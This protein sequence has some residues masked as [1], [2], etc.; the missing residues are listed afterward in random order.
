MT[1]SLETSQGFEQDKIKYHT[2][3]YTGVG[4]GLD[5]GCGPNRIWPN[6]IGMDGFQSP[7]GA[8]IVGDITDLSLFAD[9]SFPWVFSSHA[10]EDHPSSRNVEILREWWRVLKVGGYLVLY[11]PDETLYPKVGE[12]GANPAHQQNLNQGIVHSAM[13]VLRSEAGAW[14]LLVDELRSEGNEYSFLQVYRKKE[15]GEVCG[16][17]AGQ[18]C[19]KTACVV[20]FGGFG[21]MLQASSIFPQLKREGYRLTVMTTPRGHEII[22]DDPH[23]DD[24]ILQ[25]T[26]QVPNNELSDYWRVQET[27]F[28]KFVNLSESVEGTLL[29]IPGRSN[30]AWPDDVRRKRLNVNYLEFTHEL[31]GLPYESNARFYPSKE[32]GAWAQVLRAGYYGDSFLIMWSLSGSSIHK[33]YPHQDNVIARALLELPQAYFVLT[34][35]T[36]CKL[37]EQGWEAEKRV[38]RES[39]ELDIRHTLA[40][41][42]VA[43]CVVGP[44]TGV[45]NAVA[46]EERVAKVVMLSHSSHENLTKHWTRTT[47]ISAPEDR[48]VKLCHQLACHQLHYS[49]DY[50][51]EH[52]QTGAAMCQAAITPDRVFDAIRQHYAEWK[53][54]NVATS[55]GFNSLATMANS[56]SGKPAS[57]GFLLP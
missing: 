22:R 35:D 41:A 19:E 8:S 24:W 52:E 4:R 34:G 15:R 57:A 56:L 36:A 30:H 12:P 6:A 18:R 21:D 23:V 50:C 11:L 28:D 44:E 29:A 43:D 42:R 26:D 40:L 45:L 49:R 16:F 38:R 46:F 53:G 33:V 55:E 9:G 31:A 32:E 13:S 10:L 37:L 51:P 20:R 14:D 27:Y 48:S 2:V 39:G 7:Q 5:L 25:D 17:L 54:R 3:R 47:S 1:W